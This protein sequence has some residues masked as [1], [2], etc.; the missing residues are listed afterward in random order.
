VLGAARFIGRA[1]VDRFQQDN[2]DST[3]VGMDQTIRVCYLQSRTCDV[4]AVG[5]D[6][7]KSKVTLG[8]E[9]QVTFEQEISKV[10]DGFRKML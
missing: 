7:S 1:L 9:P 10:I 2:Y 6:I 8:W 3:A 5:M 4:P